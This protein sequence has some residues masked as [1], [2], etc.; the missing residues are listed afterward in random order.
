M[1][2]LTW[3]RRDL[4][5]TIPIAAALPAAPKPGETPKLGDSPKLFVDY[6]RVDLADNVVRTFHSAEKHPDNPVIGKV[7]PWE[8][9]RGTWGSVVYDD[10]A[11]LFKAWYGGNS[12]RPR[13]QSVSPAIAGDLPRQVMC[14]ATSVDGIHWDRPKLGLYEIMGSR[15]N[16]VVVGDEHHD[17]MGHWESTL[18]DPFDPNPQRR[19]KAIGWSSYD[20]DG[21]MSGIYTMTSPDGLHWTHTPEPVFHFH[22]RPNTQDLGPIGDAQAMMIDT[23]QRRYIA[24]LRKSPN[25]VM[26][27]STDFVHWTAPAMSLPARDGEQANTVYNH[28]GFVYGDRYLGY[29]TYFSRAPRDPRLTIRLV[30]SGDGEHW[31]RL[32]TGVPLIGSGPIGDVDRFTNMLCGSPPIRVG[33]RLHIYYRAMANRHTL[34]TESVKIREYEGKDLK[35]IG[36]GLCLATLRLDGFASLDA[37]YDGG[38]VMTKQ[39]LFTGSTLKVN[40]KANFGQV[41]VEVLDE[42]GKVATGFSKENCEPMHAD[43]VEHSIHWKG[44]SFADLRGKPVRLRFYLTNARLYSYRVTA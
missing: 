22:P 26:S 38:L 23:L 16:N 5:K 10:E 40:A 44:A 31:D 35:L 6:D 41:V 3:S 36:G 19:Y 30:T 21:P 43:S 29:L 24:Y 25:R 34:A 28:V 4:L 42:K 2:M 39:F 9:D 17:G 37:G 12:G 18:R 11:R 20:W 32:D 1:K 27:V 13:P 15:E 33:N 14:H 8:N 7:K